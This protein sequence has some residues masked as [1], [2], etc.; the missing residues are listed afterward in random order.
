MLKHDKE[1]YNNK[2]YNL[3]VIA[4]EGKKNSLTCIVTLL[5]RHSASIFIWHL[6]R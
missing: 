5:L 4:A 1:T 6:L 2:R 3:V